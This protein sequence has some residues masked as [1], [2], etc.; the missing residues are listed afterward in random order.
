[1]H[2]YISNTVRRVIWLSEVAESES[3]QI[4]K[5]E[6]LGTLWDSF[7][8]NNVG[9]EGGI[10]FPDG[11]KPVDLVRACLRLYSK[12]EGICLDFFAGSCTLAHA[13]MAEN[14]A[15]GGSRRFIEV[16]LPEAIDTK[17][18]Q[19]DAALS[20]YQANGIPPIITE[21]G[22]ERIRRAGRELRE[23]NLT[24]APVLDIG[25]RVLKIDT[26]N[27]KEV[28]YSPDEVKQADLIGHADHIKEDRTAEDLLFQVLVDLGV[29]LGLPIARDKIAGKT[30][31]FVDGNALAACFEPGISEELV[32]DLATRKPLRAVFRDSS[33]ESDSVK[34]K[35]GQIFKLLSP[36][37]EVKSL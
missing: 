14:A 4:I 3:G 35:V 18:K 22:K 34:I 13:V 8:Y 31:F 25:F 10:P 7:D 15:D 37:T 6:K 29:D 9:K 20:F 36:E 1:M 19:N 21:I 17:N 12:N 16:Q 11:K 30:V 26:S 28:Y 24:A 5:K 32:K 2:S 33:F 23:Q 27:M